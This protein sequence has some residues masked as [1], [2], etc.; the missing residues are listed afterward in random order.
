[1][2]DP[3]VHGN[4]FIRFIYDLFEDGAADALHADAQR[5]LVAEP[6][7]KLHHLQLGGVSDSL[8]GHDEQSADACRRTHVTFTSSPSLKG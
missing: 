2:V 7:A 5:K 4:I 3:P 6:S 8:Q 1:M